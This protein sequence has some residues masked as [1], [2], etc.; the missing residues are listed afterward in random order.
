MSAQSSRGSLPAHARDMALLIALYAREVSRGS[1]PSLATFK[2][3]WRRLCFSLLLESA[4]PEVSGAQHAQAL[5]ACALGCLRAGLSRQLRS[6][7][8][9]EAALAE[10]GGLLD[11]VEPPLEPGAASEPQAEVDAFEPL[12]RRDLSQLDLEGWMCKGAGAMA[13]LCC[14]GAQPGPTLVKICLS[15][16]DQDLLLGET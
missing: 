16:V 9:A 2:S 8:S 6:V 14:F 12:S 10:A 11:P 15:T 3:V 1:P 5:F 13:L 7:L 4:P